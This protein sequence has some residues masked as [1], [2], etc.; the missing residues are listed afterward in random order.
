MKTNKIVKLINFQSL[1]KISKFKND[2]E[3]YQKLSKDI[4]KIINELIYNKNIYF[5]KS[6]LLPDGTKPK[7]NIYIAN[8]KGLC[9][10]F[11]IDIIKKI[12]EY[13][14]DYKIIIGKK[15][16]FKD[17]M[18]LLRIDTDMFEKK[19]TEIQR[20]INDGLNEIKFS[21]INLFYIGYNNYTEYSLNEVEL[22]PLEFD[23]K[24]YD[25][26]EFVCKTDVLEVI[27]GLMS[28]YICYQIYIGVYSNMVCENI[29]RKKTTDNSLKKIKMKECKN[30]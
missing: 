28:M 25:G 11:N 26:Q 23:G 27:K 8:D 9:A 2:I 1:L 3:P 7:L 12:R 10:S 17:D 30:E 18:T 6:K 29:E 16:A 22:F 24:Y 5:D 20:I 14:D 19:L 4:I 15:I 21:E 13:P